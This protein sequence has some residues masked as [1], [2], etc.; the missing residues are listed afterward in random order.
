MEG[1][2]HNGPYCLLE[3]AAARVQCRELQFLDHIRSDV[4]C[5]LFQDNIWPVMLEGLIGD[6]LVVPSD[7]GVP[8]KDGSEWYML[9]PLCRH[10]N[11]LFFQKVPMDVAHNIIVALGVLRPR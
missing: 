5:H 7:G 2:R 1:S 11:A 8:I 4:G 3:H 9:L 6:D 10:F